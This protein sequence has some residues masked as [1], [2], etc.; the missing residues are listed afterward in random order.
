M[1]Y[2]RPMIELVYEIRRRVSADLK[3][4]IK[5]ANPDMFQELADYYHSSKDTIS[6]TLIKELFSLAGEPWASSLD[7]A[8]ESIAPRQVTKAYRGQVSLVEAKKPAAAS[9]QGT[10]PVRIY[11]GQV[12]EE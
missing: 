7:K 9:G 12:V 1:Q 6:K 5:L 3:P 8:A 2:S 11:R 10:K 4:G